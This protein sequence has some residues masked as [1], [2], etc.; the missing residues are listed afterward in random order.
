MSVITKYIHEKD[1]HNLISPAAIVPLI[2]NKLSPMSVLDVGCGVGTFLHEFKE[3]GVNDIVGVDGD[4]VK[5]E[6]MYIDASHFLTTDL[7]KPIFLGREF[8]I[9]LCLEVAEHLAETSADSIVD[10]LTKHSKQVIFSAALKY[11]GGQNHLNEQ[12]FEYWQEKFKKK[13]YYFYD[14]FRPLLWP[15]TAVQ[16]WYKQNMFLVAHKS[17]TYPADIAETLVKN[18]V[19]TCIHPDLYRMQVI[20]KMKLESSYNSVVNGEKPAWFY[21]KILTNKFLKPSNLKAGEEAKKNG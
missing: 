19:R 10:T 2:M 12:N 20:Q 8:D 5:R 13:D 21:L 3:A 17:V 16:W 15:E 11:Q 14:I 18:E 4:W 6:D 7:E 9:V 1:T